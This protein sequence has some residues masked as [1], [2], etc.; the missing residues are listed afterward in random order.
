MKHEP[1]EKYD[2]NKIGLGY[3]E[4]MDFMKLKQVYTPAPNRY[5]SHIKDSIHY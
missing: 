2:I 3:G 5:D 4:K 1:G